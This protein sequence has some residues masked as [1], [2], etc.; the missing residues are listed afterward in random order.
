MSPPTV[1][2]KGKPRVDRSLREN[3][4]LWRYL[5]TA[6]FFDFLHNK[7]LFFPRGDRFQDK[8][9]GAFTRSLRR[10]IEEAY[11]K[12]KIDFTYE[13]FRTKLRERVFLNCWHLG[14]NDSMAMWRL[15]GQS[16]CSVAITTTVGRLRAAL[17]EQKLPF[18]VS[19]EKVSYVNHWRDPKL[20]ISPYSRI[21]A[22][23]LKAYAFEREVRVLIDRS[24]DEFDSEIDDTGIPIPVSL[25][26]LLRSIVISP[27]AENWFAQLVQAITGQ[28]G[29]NAPV[30]RS[31]LSVESPI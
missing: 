24:I 13:K 21:F 27:E 2:I 9:E 17:Q 12:N 1:L 15:Y 8:F 29:V 16:P 7:R 6:K 10:A 20:D 18:H 23:K 25:K 26:T 4:V 3:L 28:N 11:A 30:H 31:K 14:P 19:I 5:D 22:Y